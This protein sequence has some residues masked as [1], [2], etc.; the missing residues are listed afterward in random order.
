MNRNERQTGG[1]EDKEK[2]ESAVLEFLDREMASVQPAQKPQSDE[3]DALVSDL[4]KQ[5]ITESDQP[6]KA[7]HILIDEEDELFAGMVP[8]AAKAPQPA[9]SQP[10]KAE[11]PVEKAGKQPP[12]PA[13]EHHVEAA[14][15]DKQAKAA[16]QV[17]FGTATTVQPKK[18]TPMMILAFGGILAAAGAGIYFFAGSSKSSVPTEVSPPAAVAEPAAAAVEPQPAPELR[19]AATEPVESK[20]ELPGPV[21]TKS[22]K[23]P[24][25]TEPAAIQLPPPPSADQVRAAAGRSNPLYNPQSTAGASQVLQQ[26]AQSSTPQLPERPAPPAPRRPAPQVTVDTAPAS[27]LEPAGPKVSGR[28][29]SPVLISQTSPVYP[30][31]AVKTKTSGTVVLDLQISAEGRVIKATPVSGPIVLRDSAVAA[32]MKWRYRPASING[33]SV[34][35]QARVSMVFNL[36]Q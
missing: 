3:L 27:K 5:V 7:K 16:P 29:T 9:P 21:Q 30:V 22:Q 17:T 14:A 32:A 20:P 11:V 23:Q 6:K 12:S 13:K 10:S 19:P 24:I 8:D 15:A 31:L 25:T 4:L 2:Y 36:K 28:P 35:S 18:R 1:F 26:I 33:S 34:A